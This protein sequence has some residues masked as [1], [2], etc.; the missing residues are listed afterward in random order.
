MSSSRRNS[1]SSG[2]WLALI[3]LAVIGYLGIGNYLATY[4]LVND[5]R[6]KAEKDIMAAYPDYRVQ[7]LEL[8]HNPLLPLQRPQFAEVDLIRKDK[9][10]CDTYITY[11]PKTGQWDMHVRAAQELAAGKNCAK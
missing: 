10:V 1:N 3:I 5:W 11:S 2:R 6:N 9:F 7:N 4:E 8:K